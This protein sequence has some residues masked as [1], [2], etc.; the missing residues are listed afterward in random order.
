MRVFATIAVALLFACSTEVTRDRWQL[1]PTSEKR[2]YVQSMIG[3]EKVKRAKGGGGRDYT[4]PVDEYVKKIDAAYA[5]G[6]KRDPADIFGE[7]SDRK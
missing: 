6:D 4:E 1:M 3:A 5:Q 2:V 7:L